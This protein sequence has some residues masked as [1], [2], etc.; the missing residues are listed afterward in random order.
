MT[1]TAPPYIE[2]PR[3]K[4][5][6]IIG[7][8]VAGLAALRALVEENGVDPEGPFEK[9]ELIERRD[10]IGGVWYL[11]ENVVKNEK[12]FP[13][14][15]ANGHWPVPLKAEKAAGIKSI[16]APL[17][18][19]NGIGDQKCRP[20]WPSPAYPALRG[21]VLPRFITLGGAPSFPPVSDPHD[22]YPSLAETQ[23]YLELIAEPL[24]PHIRTGVECVEIRELPGKT[25]KNN[26]WVIRTRDWNVFGGP[27]R[28]EY[29][30][31]VVIAIGWTDKPVYQRIAGLEEAQKAGIVEH[32]KWYRGPEPYK[33]DSR[34]V[35]VGNGNSGNDV[36]AQVAA[37]RE[38]GH[39]EPVYRIARHKPW[40]FYVSL[41]DARIKDVP[42]IEEITVSANNKK[43]SIKLADGS[44]LEDVDHII[45]ASGYEIGNFPNVHLLNRL[46]K[47][48]EEAYLPSRDQTDSTWQADT[49]AIGDLWTSLSSPPASTSF[50]VTDN[51]N[52]VPQLFW[53]F[54]HSRAAT[55]AMINLSVTSIPFWTS[56]LQSHCLRS[57][58]DG[59]F[60]D[61]P[62]ALEDRL[63]YE[64]KRIQWLV[65][66]RESEPDRIKVAQEQYIEEKK[67]N[68]NKHIPPEHTGGPPYHVIGT[69]VADYGPP[70]RSMLIKARPEWESKLPDWSA[71][72]D[73]MNAMYALK[74]RTLEKRR[75]MGL[76]GV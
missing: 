75:D 35:V 15:T 18:S 8:G 61:F 58:W 66:L 22:P 32:A 65:S 17:Q 39:H 26:R 24:R 19:E 6:L 29:F 28:T 4:S 10:N 50:N 38:L 23:R 13:G 72:L 49:R 54:L 3:P 57:I 53:Q 37:K 33:P 71:H 30:D 64:N 48:S 1:I 52:R 43:A 63:E 51:P 20:T 73:E 2:K 67:A 34:V 47:K 74:R 7:G 44:I 62:D 16:E 11:D 36:A 14:G 31:A 21:N 76:N 41:P 69:M 40:Y 55:L 9:V 59:T 56:D 68:P 12:S 5:I 70:L 45:F 46:P 42:S 25:S 27:D 60:Q